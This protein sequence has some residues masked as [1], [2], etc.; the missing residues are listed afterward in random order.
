MASLNP[1]YWVT[2]PS[3]LYLHWEKNTHFGNFTPSQDLIWI[4]L[5]QRDGITEV[6]GVRGSREGIWGHGKFIF[7][8]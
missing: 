7:I 8:C 3:N 6:V 4:P 1:Q 2:V 5:V